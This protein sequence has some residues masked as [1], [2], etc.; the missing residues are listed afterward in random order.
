MS[1]SGNQFW[2]QMAAEAD[3]GLANRGLED[4]LVDLL[5]TRLIIQA[6]LACRI[7]TES[8]RPV[9]VLKNLFWAHYG[10]LYMEETE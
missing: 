5:D 2:D 6:H 9:F 7:G 8:S 10:G 4:D 1:T 3:G